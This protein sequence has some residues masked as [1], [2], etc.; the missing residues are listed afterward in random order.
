MWARTWEIYS[1]KHEVY[2]LDNCPENKTFAIGFQINSNQSLKHWRNHLIIHVHFVKHTRW[3]LLLLLLKTVNLHIT[4]SVCLNPYIIR[5]FLMFELKVL[6][7][8]VMELATPCISSQFW[9][10][11]F[12]YCNCKVCNSLFLQ[13][14]QTENMTWFIQKLT[15]NASWIS[16]FHLENLFMTNLIQILKSFFTITEALN[17]KILNRQESQLQAIDSW[18]N[19]IT[20][21]I[22]QKF[23]AKVEKLMASAY[24]IYQKLGKS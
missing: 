21:M 17:M 15:G 1:R 8:I 2:C 6:K 9:R 13:Y 18:Y 7:W 10:V 11:K 19:A 16:G 14:N 20:S 4:S 22:S 23:A 24:Q 12:G 3:I 5:V